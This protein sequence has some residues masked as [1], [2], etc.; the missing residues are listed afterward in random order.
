MSTIRIQSHAE[1]ATLPIRAMPNAKKDGVRGEYNGML[2]VS[3]TAPAVDGKANDALVEVLKSWLG[4]SRS[5][6]VL[7]S[8]KTQR[9]KVFLIS[10]MTADELKS[11]TEAAIQ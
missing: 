3:I 5:R 2:K 1:G 10:G 6:I 4:I 7:M 9:N 11:R 8:G